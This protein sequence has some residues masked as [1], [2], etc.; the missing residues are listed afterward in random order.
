MNSIVWS[1][2]CT[3]G[4]KINCLPN[5]I[6]MLVRQDSEHTV[7]TSICLPLTLSC[8]PKLMHVVGECFSFSSD[9]QGLFLLRN[10]SWHDVCT[11]HGRVRYSWDKHMYMIMWLN[12]HELMFI[13]GIICKLTLLQLSYYRSVD[14]IQNKQKL[15]KL[16]SVYVHNMKPHAGELIVFILLERK[17][18]NTSWKV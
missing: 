4:R 18:W 17:T 6:M 13:W 7:M 9:H 15:F 5:C 16:F 2:T 14:A 8:M 3:P 11:M 12:I 1:S 10:C